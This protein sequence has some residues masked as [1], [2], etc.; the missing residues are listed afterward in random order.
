M[1]NTALKFAV[2]WRNAYDQT[3]ALKIISMALIPTFA[4]A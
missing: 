2:P 4:G 3:A 1:A